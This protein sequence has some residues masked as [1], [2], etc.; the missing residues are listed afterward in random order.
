[1]IPVKINNNSIKLNGALILILERNSFIGKY[2]FRTQTID[3]WT[4]V[5]DPGLGFEERSLQRSLYIEEY[6]YTKSKCWLIAKSI[7]DIIHENRFLNT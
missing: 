5:S 1:M 3:H 7:S 2:D 6:I 4:S